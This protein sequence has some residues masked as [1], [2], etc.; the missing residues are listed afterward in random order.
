[1]KKFASTKI[2]N[3]KNSSVKTRRLRAVAP[4]TGLRAAPELETSFLHVWKCI[5]R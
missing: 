3:A 2:A 5:A 4:K 1:M